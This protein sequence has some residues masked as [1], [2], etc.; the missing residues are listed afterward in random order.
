MLVLGYF[1]L[2]SFL[3]SSNAGLLKLI[4]FLHKNIPA[5]SNGG[6]TRLIK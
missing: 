6:H 4:K 2:V 1:F 5:C 3:K